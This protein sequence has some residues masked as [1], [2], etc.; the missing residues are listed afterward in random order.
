MCNIFR[1]NKGSVEAINN[2]QGAKPIPEGRHLVAEESTQPLSWS[3]IPGRCLYEG[4]SPHV[5]TAPINLLSGVISSHRQ[6]FFCKQSSSGII[7]P[8]QGSTPVFRVSGQPRAGSAIT[9]RIFCL[10]IS[11]SPDFK[12]TVA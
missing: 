2:F 4:S 5:S 1:G 3:S 10:F 9:F 11:L 7:G 6:P 12:H 8:F